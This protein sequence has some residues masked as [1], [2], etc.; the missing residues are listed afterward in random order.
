M[1]WLVVFA[2]F[3]TATAAADPVREIVRDRV[4]A[5]LP[6]GL[7]LIKL[8]LPASLDKV[9]VDPDKVVVEPPR[10]V[11]AGRASF[12]VIVRGRCVFVPVSIGKLVEVGV[13]RRAIP[14]GSIL[15]DADVLIVQR[16]IEAIVP[17]SGRS[18]IG[19]TAT[20]DLVADAP[21]ALRDVSF[22]PPLPRGTQVAVEIRRGSVRVRGNA[23]LE[24]AARAGEPATA[25]LAHTKTIV[26]G[27][28]RAPATLVVG[29]S[30]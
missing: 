24:L 1:R 7:G 8:H 25:R 19:A 10:A 13:A 20:R 28:L 6:A 9:D 16:A 2:L 14:A 18:L 17:A 29:D 11:G 21:V 12:K 3:G 22:P 27:T 4:E 30:P 5:L 23:T 15:T 26:R